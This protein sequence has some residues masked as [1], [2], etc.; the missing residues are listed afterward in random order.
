[1]VTAKIANETLALAVFHLQKKKCEASLYEFLKYFWPVIVQ[2]PL[3]DNWHIK[4]LCDTLQEYA[5]L[6]INRQMLIY[7]KILINIPPSSSKSTIVSVMLPAWCFMKDPTLKHLGAAYE[8]S[9]AT[10]DS[11]LCKDILKSEQ[12]QRMWP[13]RINFKSDADMKT[14]YIF[15][16]EENGKMVVGG[17]RKACSVGGSITGFH[18]HILTIDDPL[19]PKKAASDV[20]KETANKWV[21]S[22]F[23]TRK[24]DEKVSLT[25]LVMQRLAQ[26]DVTGMLLEKKGTTL[27]IC[28]PGE[29][30]ELNNVKPTECEKFYE[31]GLLDPI[32][33][34]KESLAQKKIDLGSKEY[35]GQILQHPAAMEGTIFKREWW[36]YYSVFPQTRILRVIHS[37]DTAHK[38]GK[39][40][41]K[42]AVIIAVQYPEGIFLTRA[43]SDKME[44]PELEKRVKLENSS[45]PATDILIEDKS[46]GQDLIPVL[47]KYDSLPVLPI[48]PYG[49]KLARA[50]SSTAFVEAGNVYL[51]ENEPWVTEFIDT[52]A[53]FPDIKYKDIVDAFTQ[54]INW[55]ILKPQS[56]P[57]VS[58]KKYAGSLRGY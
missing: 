27:H 8:M 38:K 7:D 14:E 10:R 4:F 44:F 58:S 50:Y 34:N 22:T 5:E 26:D 52:M 16:V 13:N 46:S 54:M 35:A 57:L 39:E 41:D 36:R 29:M 28:L 49:D 42:S 25:I 3:I 6:V 23:S 56:I 33:T 47:K 1:M 15:M 2:E 40:N 30:T 43:F 19:N 9:L 12:F 37:W 21:G 32:R 48:Q 31:N 45:R 24:I 17:G 53:G 55:V 20:E 18:G 51:P 11:M